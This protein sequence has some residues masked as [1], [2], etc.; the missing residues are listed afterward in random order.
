MVDWGI[1]KKLIIKSVSD[2]DLT[3]LWN[4]V[5]SYLTEED[6]PMIYPSSQFRGDNGIIK[7]YLL[8]EYC[9]FNG[10]KPYYPFSKSAH[11]HN[12]ISD[13][14][15]TLIEEIDGTFICRGNIDQLDMLC[16]KS[17]YQR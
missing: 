6:N 9:P 17:I 7:V 4:Y 3:D 14:K 16:N 12:K 13:Y 15:I 8:E 2:E 10:S 11:F 1:V 5:T